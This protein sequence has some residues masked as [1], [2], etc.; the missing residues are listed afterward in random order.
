MVGTPDGG[1]MFAAEQTD[2]IF[3]LDSNHK[4]YIFVEDT[5]G[6]GA[7]ALDK[8]GRV[9][10]VQ[11]ACTGPTN[12]GLAGC[13]ELTTISVLYPERRVLASAFPNGDPFG[14]PLNDL[15]ADGKGGVYFTAND[16]AYHV[17]AKGVVIAVEE[18]D[19][20]SNG[21]MLSPDERTLYVTNVTEVLAFDIQPDWSVKNRRVFGSL[22]GDNGAEGM[23]VDNEGRLYITANLGV[24]VLSPAGQYL[25]LIPS[26]RR[27]ITAAFSGPDKKI[28][29]ITGAGAVGPTGQ[30]FQPP[31]GMR[32]SSAT[33]YRIPMV[34]QG[35]LGRPK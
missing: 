26:K 32:T 3:K 35:F 28:L 13:N 1:V 27:A 4:V 29:Y 30:P 14:R 10:A 25:G 15:V 18:Q 31:E 21:I 20:R 2:K 17:D 33:I 5:N 34:A 12:P 6:G 9:Y 22:N 16:R 8:E 11:R 19:I 24:H 23:V 7:V